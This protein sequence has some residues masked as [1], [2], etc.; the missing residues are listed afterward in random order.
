MPDYVHFH[1]DHRSVTFFRLKSYRWSRKQCPDV[2]GQCPITD[3]KTESSPFEMR[4]GFPCS[5]KIWPVEIQKSQGVRD[6]EII[7]Q[8]PAVQVL[9]SVVQVVLESLH[10][11]SGP[12][13]VHLISNQDTKHRLGHIELK[14]LVKLSREYWS[15]ID[16]WCWM[17][18]EHLV[19]A[20]AHSTL[21]HLFPQLCESAWE[22]DEG[23][24]LKEEWRRECM[25]N[26]NSHHWTEERACSSTYQ[27]LT[28]PT[29]C[30]Y[31]GSFA[32]I[33]TWVHVTMMTF[34][35]PMWPRSHV[36]SQQRS[37]KIHK[38]MEWEMLL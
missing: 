26:M 7:G 23:D 38:V 5:V 13:G 1:K 14:A 21:S 8:L 27:L 3:L 37:R 17:A 18:L 24:S 11:R 25:S 19:Q 31:L 32:P 36:W 4:K 35:T 30:P 34:I 2:S 15:S 9:E 12:W 6:E 28:M 10:H 20:G 29:W 16:H 33:R 22:D